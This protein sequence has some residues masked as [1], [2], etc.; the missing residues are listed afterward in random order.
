AGQVIKYILGIGDRATNYLLRFDMLTMQ[1]NKYELTQDPQCELC[2]Q[3][4]K[5]EQVTK[6]HTPGDANMLEIS[7]TELKEKLK[8]N[9]EFLLL[10]VRMPEEHVANNIGGLLIP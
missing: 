2:N 3:N 10:D 8:N 5:N 4:H 6:S 7:A 1:L 9:D